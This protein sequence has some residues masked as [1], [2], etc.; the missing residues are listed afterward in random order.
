MPFPIACVIPTHGRPEYLTQALGGILAQTSAPAEVVVVD[1]LDDA[2]T[3][4]V[5]A[6][7]ARQAPFPV[8]HVV[9]RVGGG[10]SGSRNAGAAASTAPV[11]AFLDDDDAWRPDYLSQACD[12]LRQTGAEV[13]ISGLVRFRQDGVVQDIV[14]PPLRDVANRMYEKNFGM[15]GSNLMITRAAFERVGGFDPKLPVFNDWDF[16][17]RMIKAGVAYVTLADLL[18]E[19]REHGGDRI[20]TPTLRRAAGIE[21]FIAKHEADMPPI[22]RRNLIADALGIRRRNARSI[23][24]RAALAA[25]LFCLLGPREAISRRLR[26]GR[27][28][29]LEAGYQP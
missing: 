25:R 29:A 3:A 22:Q 13:V 9:N 10:A 16:L 2:R 24:G 15:T 18:V 5:V 26:P 14:M 11:L 23:L 28:P 17:I 7:A 19:W 4:A 20:S 12:T 1:D 21:T 8:R 6:A 27:R